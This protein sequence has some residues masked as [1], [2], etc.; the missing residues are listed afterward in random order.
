MISRHY[1]RIDN[2]D[3]SLAPAYLEIPANLAHTF[4]RRSV[5]LSLYGGLYFA[6]AFGGYKSEAGYKTLTLG[7]RESK[8]LKIID[9]GFN[10]G[11]GLHIRFHLISIQYGT[12]CRNVSPK[13]DII[14]RN[15][16]FG[17]SIS[18]LSSSDK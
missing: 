9:Y 5:R 16:V 4:G 1:I 13:N 8:D 18:S 2:D 11:P 14:M 12:G 17:V 7:P 10:F 15:K 3:L 6:A